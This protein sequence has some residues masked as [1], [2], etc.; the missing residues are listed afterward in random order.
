M[1][2]N[3][4]HTLKTSSTVHKGLKGSTNT[5]RA[6]S[7]VDPGFV[8]PTATLAD[9]LLLEKLCCRCTVVVVVAPV[10][11]RSCWTCCRVLVSKK[12]CRLS[13]CDAG[14]IY[15]KEYS[16]RVLTTN[17][18]VRVQRVQ[19]LDRQAELTATLTLASCVLHLLLLL[20]CGR[21]TAAVD[22]VHQYN[23]YSGRTCC[24]K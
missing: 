5:S 10:S 9:V 12:L 22:V 20:C 14:N 21:R 15:K 18:Y 19:G 6:Y 23:K 4:K 3:R 11:R 1:Y 2:G 17:V 8:G 16:S 24:E 7:D 13:R